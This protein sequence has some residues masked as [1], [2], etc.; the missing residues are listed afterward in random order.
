MATNSFIRLF[1][2]EMHISPQT[3]VKRQ[4]IDRACM[5]LL[6]T[7]MKIEDIAWSLDFANRYHFSIFNNKGLHFDGLTPRSDTQDHSTSI[8]SV[9]SQAAWPSVL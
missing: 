2:N 8:S 4:K 5:L 6:H 7:D 3:Y 1:Q 9:N